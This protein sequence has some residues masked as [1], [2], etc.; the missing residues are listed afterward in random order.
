MGAGV[1][2][3]GLALSG[4]ASAPRARVGAALA[5]G[6]LS[7]A[8]RE[9]E[10]L[11]VSDGEDTEL[12]ARVAGLLLEQE[13]ASEDRDRRR[14]AVQ[15]LG[16]AGP[17]GR[18]ILQRVVAGAG[19]GRLAALESLARRGDRD[20][21]R[22]LRGLADSEDPEARAASVLGMD[23]ELDR[24]LLLDWIASPSAR[25]RQAVA[26]RL[27][28]LTI[29]SEAQQALEAAARV[30]P[31]PA[32]RAACVRALGEIGPNA[33][34]A[35]R[36]RLSDESASVRTAAVDALVRADR[37]RALEV[38]GALLAMPPSPAGIEAA[39]VIATPLATEP[40]E[41]AGA[42]DARAYLRGALSSSDPTLRAQAGVALAGM[43]PQ[44]GV[45][46]S[47][48]AA[49]AAETDDGARLSLA[50]ALL[51]QPSAQV[52]A[53]AALAA[54][55]ERDAAMNG[56]QAATILAA[57]GEE[58]AR[59]RLRAFLEMPDA[60]LRRVAARA[61][62]RDAMRPDE[63]RVALDDEDALVRIRAAGGILAAYAAVAG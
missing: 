30:D 1:I 55:M 31:E 15:E 24:A 62:A 39:R 54:L 57:E 11:R 26:E 45:E 56:L 48:R 49:L 12:L 23:V 2:A 50:R 38:L 53:R 19:P 51:R 47:L 16:L 44:E 18:P 33:V 8:R 58:S 41:P 13:A 9:Y 14:A 36:E 6:D 5:A 3:I 43:P 40:E 63:A 46:I 22:E 52:D 32:V 35:L 4:C 10:V 27:G 42:R 61:L 20:A 29:D 7:L 28:E 21:R 34:E 17:M 37:A 25:V 60:T 59:Q